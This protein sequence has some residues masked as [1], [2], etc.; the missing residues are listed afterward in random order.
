[1]IRRAG[2]TTQALHDEVQ[3]NWRRAKT[4]FET[5]NSK[6]AVCRVKFDDGDLHMGKFA[7]GLIVMSGINVNAQRQRSL[8]S[9]SNDECSVSCIWAEHCGVGKDDGMH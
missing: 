3:A 5:L 9:R 1:M 2:V 4:A 7:G 8:H 6:T